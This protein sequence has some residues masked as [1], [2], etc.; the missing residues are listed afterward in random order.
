MLSTTALHAVRAMGELARLKAGSYAGAVAI[1]E[2]IGAPRNYLGKLLQTL[3]SH[4][5]VDSRKG[6]GGGF[7]LAR[8]AD[9]ITLYDVVEPID[10]VSRWNGCFLGNTRCNGS[11]RIHRRYRPVREAYLNM[12]RQS[13]IEEVTRSSESAAALSHQGEAAY[14]GHATHDDPRMPV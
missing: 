11:C 14:E 6:A 2:K 4:G 3:S 8:P 5:L 1:A 12:L 9:S 10:R 7:R 13:T